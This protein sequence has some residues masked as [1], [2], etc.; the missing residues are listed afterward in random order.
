[1]E[2][3]RKQCARWN[4]R[5]YRV[6]FYV[7]FKTVSLVAEKF[8]R[9]QARG[10]DEIGFELT[11]ERKTDGDENDER[12][13]TRNPCRTRIQRRMPYEKK[14]NQIKTVLGPNTIW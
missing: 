5:D 14:K 4:G 7:L 8:F 10:T 11:G 3:V 13:E 12:R 1:M 6:S 2:Y 9:P